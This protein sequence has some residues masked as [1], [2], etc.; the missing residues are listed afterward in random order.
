MPVTALEPWIA[1][2]VGGYVEC[3]FWSSSDDDGRHLD[4]SKYA[5]DPTPELR[6]E[7]A[8]DVHAFALAHPI[9]CRD[10]LNLD[11]YSA[12]RLGCDLW[13]TRNGHG[14]GFWDRDELRGVPVPSVWG[15]EVYAADDLANALTQAAQMMGECHLGVGDDG[16]VCIL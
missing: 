1:D 10:A 9:L 14:V 6:A 16:R 12:A 8:A 4:A 11:G 3:A 7:L 5:D 15:R 13:T 2:A